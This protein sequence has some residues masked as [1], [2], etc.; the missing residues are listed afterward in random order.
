M[1]ALK[2]EVQEKTT[3]LHPPTDF[4]ACTQHVKY[5]CYNHPRHFENDDTLTTES[6]TVICLFDDYKNIIICM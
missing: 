6:D 2:N 5:I 4:F 1:S 3:S